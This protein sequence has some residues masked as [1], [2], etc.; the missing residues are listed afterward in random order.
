MLKQ[1]KGGSKG[2]GEERSGRKEKG[3]ARKDVKSK[4][5]SKGRGGDNVRKDQRRGEK[6][7]ERKYE[8]R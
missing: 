7:M 6:E 3:K 4:G 5:G 8:E 1:R 2:K